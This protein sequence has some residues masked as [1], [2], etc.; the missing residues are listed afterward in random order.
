MAII[1]ITYLFLS[2]YF[3]LLYV[4]ASNYLDI[5]NKINILVIP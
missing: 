1:Y 4:L 5:W 3:Q 2:L